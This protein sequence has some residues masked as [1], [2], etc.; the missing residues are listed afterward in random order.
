MREAAAPPCFHILLCH[1][2]Q[3][4]SGWAWAL[5]HPSAFLK[6]HQG[7]NQKMHTGVRSEM[8]IQPL[9][10]ALG[11]ALP[12]ARIIFAAQI[13]TAFPSHQLVENAETALFQTIH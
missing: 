9:R 6:G 10:T 1:I 4:E 11:T 7:E 13:S 2:L 3:K 8:C 12:Q 5:Q